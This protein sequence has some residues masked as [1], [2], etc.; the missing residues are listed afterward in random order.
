MAI[1]LTILMIYRQIL[2]F[3]AV[4]RVYGLRSAFF[5]TLVLPIVPIRVAMGN[6]INFHAT[7]KAWRMRFFKPKTVSVKKAKTPAKPLW[8]KTDHEFLDEETLVRFSRTLGDDLIKKEL[9]SP[10]D[11]SR[12]LKVAKKN[13]MFLGKALITLGAIS[14]EEVIRSITVIQNRQFINKPIGNFKPSNM[15]TFEKEYFAKELALPIFEDKHKITVMT[16]VDYNL[17]NVKAKLNK[18]LEIVYCTEE[19]LKQSLDPTDKSNYV[20]INLYII[21]Q[22]VKEKLIT[23]MQ[24][25]IAINYTCERDSI[26]ETLK[27]MGLL[28]NIEH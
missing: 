25:I 15:P 27:K 14:E 6:F 24:G 11:L 2:R 23:T 21:E 4:K 16:T 26:E 28:R 20:E 10:E 9:I 5:S 3:I 7:V 8:T 18:P 19:I 13:D 17:D 1:A 12:A 22:L